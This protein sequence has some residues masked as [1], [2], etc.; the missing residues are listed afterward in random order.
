MCVVYGNRNSSTPRRRAARDLSGDIG[1]HVAWAV[2]PS[3]RERGASACALCGRRIERRNKSKKSR[4]TVAPRGRDTQ[5]FRSHTGDRTRDGTG[6]RP[7]RRGRR[8]RSTHII[9]VL[10]STRYSRARWTTNNQ[11]TFAT[12]HLDISA[13]I[14]ALRLAPRSVLARYFLC[15]WGVRSHATWIMVQATW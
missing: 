1:S 6:R 8:V 14:R 7:V 11:E 9:T 4:H 15:Y 13:A 5:H 2:G 3:A 10:G 12:V